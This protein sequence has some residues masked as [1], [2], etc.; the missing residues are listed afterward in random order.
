MGATRTVTLVVPALI[1]AVLA[2]VGLSSHLHQELAIAA[3]SIAGCTG[4]ERIDFG[5]YERRYRGIVAAVGPRAAIADLREQVGT[6][7]VCRCCLPPAVAWHRPRRGAPERD[8]RLRPGRRQLLVRLLPRRG[9]GGHGANGQRADP[10]RRLTRVLPV[11]EPAATAAARTTT[12]CTGW[13]T[14]SWRSTGVTSSGRST[15]APALP[16]SWERGHCEGGVFMQNLTALGHTA[17][18]PGTSARASPSIRARR[19]RRAS[20]TSAT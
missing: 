2:S 5:C 19:W 13:A 3:P 4:A 6:H 9:R 11:T 12:A 20:S 8:P 15:A 1:A 16:S 18:R 17:A 7:R 10:A 14:A